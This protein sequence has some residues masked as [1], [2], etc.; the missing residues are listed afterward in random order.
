[1][2]EEYSTALAATHEAA[3]LEWALAGLRWSAWIEV[4]RGARLVFDPYLDARLL[5]GEIQKNLRGLALGKLSP[6]K[7]DSHLDAAIDGARERLNDGPVSQHIG[8]HVDF[9][10]GAIDKRNVDVFEVLARRVVNFWRGIGAPLRAQG[11]N[12]SGR[13]ERPG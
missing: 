12:H 13:N 4:H 2:E 1:M 5:G 3:A 10:L 7:V 9:M 6:V 11:E 8:R